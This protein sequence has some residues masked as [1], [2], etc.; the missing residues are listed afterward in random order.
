MQQH[1]RISLLVMVVLLTM[2]SGHSADVSC[3]T[4]MQLKCVLAASACSLCKLMGAA[5]VW[6][7]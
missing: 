2:S 4:Y 6:N 1:L 3:T 5:A 7:T